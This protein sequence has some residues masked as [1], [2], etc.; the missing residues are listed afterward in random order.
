MSET[1]ETL[2]E[3]LPLALERIGRWL[4]TADHSKIREFAA[5]VMSLHAAAS[6]YI[7]LTMEAE[8]LR[9]ALDQYANHDVWL[10]QDH[11]NPDCEFCDDSDRIC[12][13]AN[14]DPGWRI[15]EEARIRRVEAV[16]MCEQLQ[17]DLRATAGVA[18]TLLRERDEAREAAR[19]LFDDYCANHVQSVVDSC[20]QRW[21]W[22]D[23]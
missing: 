17:H 21:P 15:A 10:C 20:Y 2:G 18:E 22:L 11:W 4:G 13:D 12:F 8:R 14:A 19:W 5:D 16:A 7:K 23:E 9:K 1:S 6:Q 3:R